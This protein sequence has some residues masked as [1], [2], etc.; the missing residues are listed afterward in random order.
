M[1]EE[2]YNPK[3][4]SA[5]IGAKSFKRELNKR[6]GLKYKSGDVDDWL[7]K[8]EP[9]TLHKIIVN[10]FQRR[11]TTAAEPGVQ[12]QADLLDVQSHSRDNEGYRFI[13]TVIDIFSK[14]AW[15]I[16]LKT[17]GGEV[18]ARALDEICSCDAPLYL[19]TDKGKGFYN[20]HVCSAL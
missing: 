7:M 13:L 17:K 10:K 8:Q 11:N 18:V 20:V 15:A 5:Y 12:Y 2:Y 6:N 14:K 1:E 19:Q 4:S 3:K 9:Y 16:P